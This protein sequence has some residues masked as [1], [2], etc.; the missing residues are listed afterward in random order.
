MSALPTRI[1]TEAGRPLTPLEIFDITAARE[2]TL[3]RLLMLYIGTGLIFMLLKS[4]SNFALESQPADR[5]QSNPVYSPLSFFVWWSCCP[6]QILRLDLLEIEFCRTLS[7]GLEHL[8]EWRRLSLNPAQ[9]VDA[10][11]HERAQVRAD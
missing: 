1:E 2:A 5:S 6:R 9:R 10:R 11:Y 3:S 7:H 4:H 8:F